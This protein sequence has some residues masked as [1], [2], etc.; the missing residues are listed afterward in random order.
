M[1][2]N[3]LILT[4]K[5]IFSPHKTIFKSMKD[6]RK[7]K[8][9]A[10]VYSEKHNETTRQDTS[11]VGVSIRYSQVLRTKVLPSTLEF[12]IYSISNVSF[13]ILKKETEA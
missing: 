10:N 11:V 1:L 13:F 5:D 12:H 3:I 8:Q 9:L 6:E 7:K 2:K 4:N